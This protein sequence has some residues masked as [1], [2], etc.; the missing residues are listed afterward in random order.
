MSTRFSDFPYL[1]TVP[2][3]GII[4][5]LGA[6]GLGLG[7]PG[8]IGG[9]AF[10][11]VWSLGLGSIT[12]RLV[13]RADWRRRLANG[14][15]FFA[16]VT[17]GIML[18]G[19]VMYALLMKAAAA[20][21]VSVLSDLMQP[22]VPFFIILN[23]PLELL[24]VPVAVSTNWHNQRRRQLILVAAAAFYTMR[25]W[26]YLVYVPARMEIASRPLL[27]EDV[28]WFRHSMRADYRFVLDAVVL[29]AFT[30]AALVPDSAGR[31]EL[32]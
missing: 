29:I 2:M 19:G 15:I 32:T 17:M 5:A 27:P 25:V 11:L 10:G 20:A 31:E 4:V 13:R 8:I 6:T 26:S 3:T 30:A 16:T 14:S 18:G 12:K 9:A 1:A 23:T 22:T 24:V 7:V 28:E 21:S